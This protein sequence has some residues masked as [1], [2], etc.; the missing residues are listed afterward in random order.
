MTYND[1]SWMD[2]AECIAAGVGVEAFCADMSQYKSRKEAKKALE[3]VIQI[4]NNCPVIAQ[5]EE[6]ATRLKI[7]G[8]G[9]VYAGKI[10]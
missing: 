10:R 8:T 7:K 6:Y 3:Y 2:D 4:C 9:V 1:L 5:C